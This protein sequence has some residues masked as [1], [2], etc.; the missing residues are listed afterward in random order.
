MHSVANEL[1]NIARFK[2]D[3]IVWKFAEFVEC[4]IYDNTGL[5]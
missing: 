5:K 3:L 4:A 2:I 1:P